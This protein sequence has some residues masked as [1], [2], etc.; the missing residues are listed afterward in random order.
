M[1]SFSHWKDSVNVFTVKVIVDGGPSDQGSKHQGARCF[2]K[3]KL[4]SLLIFTKNLPSDRRLSICAAED[5][6]NGS[7]TFRVSGPWTTLG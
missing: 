4:V 5:S 3:P 2:T 1:E 7:F 6:V